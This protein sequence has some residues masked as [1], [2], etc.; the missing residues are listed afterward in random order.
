[1]GAL[2]ASE[3]QLARALAECPSR[4]TD[5]GIVGAAIAAAMHAPD[6]Y[7]SDLIVWA[8]HV[9]GAGLALDPADSVAMR[10]VDEAMGP[11][12]GHRVQ[13]PDGWCWQDSL[14]ERLAARAGDDTWTGRAFLEL[15]ERGWQSRCELCGYDPRIGTDLF[16]PVIE[17][18]D[19]FLR[20]H[21]N[22]PIAR[23]VRW[24]VAEAHETAWSLSRAD[25]ADEYIEW[26]RY[27][28]DAP[29]HRTRA[30]EFYES[31]LRAEPPGPRRTAVLERLAR[32]RLDVD[33][34]FHAFWC[35][36]D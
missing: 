33:T 4:A 23:E 34:G 24:L 7:G 8:G 3:P 27:V 35:E 1:V 9:W 13:V 28:L 17:R 30:I 31:L 15:M 32:L 16:K 19:A 6:T 36:W 11:V 10:L 22:S 12:G 21:G 14:A 2:R 29:G 25:L 18:G 26:S 5:A 20:Q